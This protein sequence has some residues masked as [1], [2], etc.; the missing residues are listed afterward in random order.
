MG[1][2]TAL[3][4]VDAV[5]RGYITTEQA[6]RAHINSNFYPPHPEP[7]ADVAV[8]AVELANQGKADDIIEHEMWKQGYSVRYII[9]RLHLEPFVDN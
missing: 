4:Y 7:M 6:I 9:E 2:V 8:R 3:G 1:R 5:E